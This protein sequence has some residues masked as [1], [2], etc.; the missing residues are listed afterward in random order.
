[1]H[2]YQGP[3]LARLSAAARIYLSDRSRLSVPSA[4]VT[5]P[6]NAFVRLARSPGRKP[7]LDRFGQRS[8]AMS[9]RVVRS[10]LAYGVVAAA[11]RIWRIAGEETAMTRT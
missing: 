10:T 4:S 7:G 3:A 11:G 1:M 8:A 6:I 9:S 5:D 2:R